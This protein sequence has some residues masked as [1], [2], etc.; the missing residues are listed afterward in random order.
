MSRFIYTVF[1][2][3]LFCRISF[4]QKKDCS[5]QSFI[6]QNSISFPYLA[7]CTVSA[8]Q[9]CL[10]LLRR[11]WFCLYMPFASGISARICYVFLSS[12]QLHF[13]ALPNI[14]HPDCPNNGFFLLSTQPFI[15]RILV[16][17]KLSY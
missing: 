12:P 7:I 8:I 14:C 6:V 4:K 1:G 5:Q 9:I 11:G 15:P 2:I 16:S 17:G 3:I 13:P 10:F